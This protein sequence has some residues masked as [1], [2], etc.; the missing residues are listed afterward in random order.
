MAT[1]RDYY[2]VLG[3]PRTATQD[4]LKKAFRK[5]TLQYHPDRNPGNKE[6]EEKFKEA[7]EAYG[8]LRDENKRARYD[9][10]GFEGVG[11]SASSG[12]AADI[13][14]QFGDIFG[15]LGDLF[16]G[17]FGGAFGGGGS[18]GPMQGA[19]LRYS[20]TISFEQAAGG[21]E[22][23]LNVPKHVPCETC[24][25]TGAAPGT[26]PQTCPRC[27]GR[28]QIRQSQGFFSISRPCPECHGSGEYIAKPCPDCHGEGVV[29][30]VKELYVKVPPGVDS[31]TRLRVHGEGE[32]GLHG[33]PPGNLYVLIDVEDSDR[34]VRQ[35]QDLLYT[36]EISFVQAALGCRITF[37]GLHG[38][39]SL[40]IPKGTQSG[41]VLRVPHEGL[42]Y[43]GRSQKGDMLVEV[44]VLTPTRLT[45]RQVEILKEFEEISKK[46]GSGFFDKITENI[47]ETFSREKKARKSRKG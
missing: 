22:V 41:R 25:G 29:R 31:G 13:F 14:A 44:K 15:D 42:P 10:F 32:P 45:D 23:K 9:Q 2:E 24:H 7:A 30:E 5:L 4:E 34:Y 39:L 16:G 47:K 46:S 40:D 27:R 36:A 19:D 35:G 18:G 3:V 43:I 21:D 38:D 1:K 28:G 33:G 26:R 6:A 12:S 17:A 20:L 37:P 8:V 11:S